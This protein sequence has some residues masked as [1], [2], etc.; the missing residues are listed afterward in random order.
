MGTRDNLQLETQLLSEWIT[1]AGWAERA[2]THVPVGAATL[3]YNGQPL[4]PARQ[5]AFG[6]WNDWADCR[7]FTGAQVWLVE[8]K[9]VNVG[10][11]YGQLL[12]YLDEYPQSLDYQEFA[13]APVV[14][15]VLCAF[16]RSRTAAVFQRLGVRTIVYTPSWAGD[17]L[18]NKVFS[19]NVS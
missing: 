11:V 16:L 14:P 9:I 8:A 4:S 12:D 19:S 2:R 15:V 17:T 18:A 13:P 1:T 7:I 6:V 3:Q 10:T 5:R